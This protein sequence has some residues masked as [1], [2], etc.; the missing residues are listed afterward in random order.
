MAKVKI[1]SALIEGSLYTVEF[2]LCE[3]DGTTIHSQAKVVQGKTEEEVKEKIRP[4]LEKYINE[5]QSKRDLIMTMQVKA[6]ELSTEV[7]AIR[8]EQ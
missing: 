4:Y 2:V 3:D 5:E 6:D 7:S 1:I 8:E